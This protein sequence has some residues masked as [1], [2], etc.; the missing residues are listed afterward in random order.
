MKDMAQLL[1]LIPDQ[2]NDWARRPTFPFSPPINPFKVPVAL[3][4]DVSAIGI[5]HRDMLVVVGTTVSDSCR[6][7]FSRVQKVDGR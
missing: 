1:A 3:L 5:I 2:L 7:I 4:S 6:I